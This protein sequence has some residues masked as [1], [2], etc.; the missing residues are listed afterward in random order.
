MLLLDFTARQAGVAPKSIRQL[1][2][3]DRTERGF[4]ARPAHVDAVRVMGEVVEIEADL[5]AVRPNDVSDLFEKARLAVSGE[6]H[7]FVLVAVLGEPEELGERGVEDAKGVREVHGALDFDA[8]AATD[9]PHDTA[10][11][12]E[13]VDGDHGG[14]V[15]RGAKEGAGEVSAVMFDEV[16]FGFAVDDADGVEIGA[17]PGHADGVAGA[18]SY[19]RPVL[20]ARGG[21]EHFSSEV[22]ARIARDGNMVGDFAVQAGSSSEEREAGPVFDAVEALL[23]EGGQ[24]FPIVEEFCRGVAVKCV[25]AENGHQSIRK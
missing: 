23:F 1:A 4:A 16:D 9:A 8:V 14:W 11:V 6:T 15:E 5:I 20:R 25:E 2:R 24:D 19:A 21:A 18:G 17:N 22:S 3:V 7:H 13:A 10:E 12:A